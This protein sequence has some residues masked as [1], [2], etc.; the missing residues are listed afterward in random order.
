[1]NCSWMVGCGLVGPRRKPHQDMYKS[2]ELELHCHEITTKDVSTKE[3]GVTFIDTMK[4][5]EVFNAKDLSR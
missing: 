1:M 3:R 5:K 2:P 4:V